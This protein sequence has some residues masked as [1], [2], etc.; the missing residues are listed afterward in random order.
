MVGNDNGC[1]EGCFVG[2]EDGIPK[3]C[4]EGCF[5][6]CILGNVDGSVDG[7]DD[8]RDRGWPV[9]RELDG[10]D[11]G[12]FVKPFFVGLEVTGARVGREE[13]CLDGWRDG[14]IEG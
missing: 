8:G 5:E 1:D 3:G 7:C 2:W 11:V 13:G 9:G 10:F 12:G 6:G 14:C 4:F